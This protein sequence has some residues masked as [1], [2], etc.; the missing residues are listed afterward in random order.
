MSTLVG[1]DGT[2][3]VFLLCHA[4]FV[5]LF[6]YDF[7]FFVGSGERKQNSYGTPLVKKTQDIYIMSEPTVFIER[8]QKVFINS[9]R[10]R[11]VLLLQQQ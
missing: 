5:F 6:R 9:T 2:V 8:S 3:T 7:C 4:H 1:V 10:R 11:F